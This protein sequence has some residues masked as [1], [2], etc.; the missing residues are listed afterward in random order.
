LAKDRM[1]DTF[2]VDELRISVYVHYTQGVWTSD[3]TDSGF[4]DRRKASKLLELTYGFESKQLRKRTIRHP[5]RGVFFMGEPTE[6]FG[7]SYRAG[8]TSFEQLFVLYQKEDEVFPVHY[9]Q[10]L[11]DL[12]S[13]VLGRLMGATRS[14]AEIDVNN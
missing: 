6:E 9:R 12:R 10:A 3:T 5:K 13:V 4:A 11:D 1:S 7:A 14:I 8:K 2:D